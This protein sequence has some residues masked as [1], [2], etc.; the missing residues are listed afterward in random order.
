V[1][2]VKKT[3]SVRFHLDI[4]L[5]VPHDASQLKGLSRE[6]ERVVR[7]E[8]DLLTEA[9]ITQMIPSEGERFDWG[10]DA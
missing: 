6:I 8:V 10:T 2:K 4:R 3:T 9:R 7:S 1:D 5:S